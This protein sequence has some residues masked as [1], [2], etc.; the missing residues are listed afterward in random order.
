MALRLLRAASLATALLAAPPGA[1]AQPD[2]AALRET[3]G[4]LLGAVRATT[5]VE[6]DSPQA[7]LGRALFWDIRLS[8]NG[9]VACASCHYREN[10]GSDSRPKSVD[11]RG[12]PTGRQSQTVF[13]AMEASGLR[14]LADRANGAAQAESSITGSMGFARAG[15]I[16]PVLHRLGYAEGFRAAFPDRADPVTPA[17]YAAALQAYQETL[18]TPAPFD[19]WLAG[20]EAAL[21]PA[22]RRGLLRFVE[23]GCAGC[24]DGPLLGGRLMQRFGVVEEYWRQTGSASVDQGLASVTRQ[25]AD[26]FVFRVPL[27]RN[28]AR[29]P[30]YFHDGSVADLAEATRIMARVQLGQE[31]D[32]TAVAEIV[33]FLEAL[34]GEL[35]AHFSPPPGVPFE[36]PPGVAR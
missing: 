22:Q 18:R 17:G 5:E 31:L 23:T 29:T 32:A 19:R 24:H 6:I 15:D 27:L 16:V 1:S 10:W 8:G 9:E 35:P 34:T 12:R 14:W 28:V 33:V 7:R 2:P 25:E 26:R 36:L 11:A 21:T 3:A 4:R 30:P 13:H 20:E